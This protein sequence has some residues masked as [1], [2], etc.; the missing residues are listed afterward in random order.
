[1]VREL[2]L[3]E[4]RFFQYFRMTPE[5]F[6]NLL[7]IVGP[8]ICKQTTN[9]RN[10]ISPQQRLAICF[11]FLATVLYGKHITFQAPPNSADAD[12]CFTV[13]DI[14]SY[15]SNSDGG[16]FFKFTTGSKVRATGPM[17]YVIVGAEA[18]PLK[19][20]LLRPYPGRDLSIDKRIFNYRLSRARRISE[21]AF[22]LLA[23]RWRIFQR[24]I[25]LHPEQCEK[26]VQACSVLDNY[27]QKST[28]FLFFASKYFI[29]F[30]ETSSRVVGQWQCYLQSN[31]CLL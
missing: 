30:S 27:L 4:Q 14:G 2:R 21:N 31:L 16:I 17:P 15:G 29:I 19:T 5:T 20:Y 10:P 23:Q 1:K 11:R 8:H 7:H 24:R 22:G 6:D 9:Y 28:G 26:V 18:F 3:D 13:I 25:N 12:Y